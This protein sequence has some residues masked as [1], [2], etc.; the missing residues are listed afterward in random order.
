MGTNGLITSG[1]FD[2]LMDALRGVE[3]V[4][5]VN[6]RVPR[7]WEG[8]DNDE[9]RAGVARWPNAVM[10][11]WHAEGNAHPEWFWDDGYHLRPTVPP[12]TRS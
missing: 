12:P 7:R 9:L 10:L 11:D 2:A 3:R 6:L 5:V 4:V 8:Q 1:E